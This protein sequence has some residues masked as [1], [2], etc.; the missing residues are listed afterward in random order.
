[1]YSHRIASQALFISTAVTMTARLKKRAPC[2]QSQPQC[3]AASGAS[4]SRLAPSRSSADS[5]LY[6]SAMKRPPSHIKALHP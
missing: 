6:A 2:K 4:A 3:D 5:S 1:M